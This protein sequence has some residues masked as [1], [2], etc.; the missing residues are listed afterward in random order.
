MVIEIK[1]SVVIFLGLVLA[2]I[3]ALLPGAYILWV[4]VA[5]LI[6]GALGLLLYFGVRVSKN[7]SDIVTI[8]VLLLALAAMGSS[9]LLLVALLYLSVAMFAIFVFPTAIN[10]SLSYL[11]VQVLP[12][13]HFLVIPVFLLVSIVLA[14]NVR[15]PGMLDD[16]LNSQKAKQNSVASIV[17]LTQN[18]P[19]LLISNVEKVSFRDS[20]NEPIGFSGNE[21]CGCFFWTY[22]NTIT[23]D[24]EGALQR[25]GIRYKKSGHARYKLVIDSHESDGVTFLGI[26]LWD[27]AQ[28]TASYKTRLRTYHRHEVGFGKELT[29]DVDYLPHRLLF[30]AQNNPWNHAL[31]FLTQAKTKQPIA[32]F[33]KKSIHIT[34][35]SEGKPLGNQPFKVTGVTELSTAFQPYIGKL[36]FDKII[37]VVDVACGNGIKTGLRFNTEPNGSFSLTGNTV[38]FSE[39]AE[40][41]TVSVM[42]DLE[43]VICTNNAV[44]VVG[45]L[46]NQQEI[47]VQKFSRRGDILADH[48]IALPKMILVGFPRKPIIE[49]SEQGQHYEFTLLDV[50]E[51]DYYYSVKGAYRIRAPLNNQTTK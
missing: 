32:D 22:P 48:N 1:N 16:W 10:L 33:L 19:L 43:K 46:T 21:G 3:F 13:R 11:A 39:S 12:N 31:S 9:V 25:H 44:Y 50:A 42:R 14:L 15:I 49:F 20:P 4:A 5:V 45:A 40:T 38:T 34:S 37:E 7:K 18:E 36:D 17:R 47:R 41:F 26:N 28:K 24:V 30:L 29:N 51:Q 27:G 6:V 23:E 35:P 8:V 2:I